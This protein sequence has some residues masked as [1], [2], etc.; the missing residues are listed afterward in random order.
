MK[1]SLTWLKEFV[2]F[3][4]PPQAL[5]DRLTA[6]GCEITAIEQAGSDWVIESEITP[7]RPDLLSHLGLAREI[8]AALGREFRPPRWLKRQTRPFVGHGNAVPVVIEEAE[9]CRRYIGITIDNV[10]VAPST[11]D[12]QKRLLALGI[13]PVNNVVDITNLCMLELGQPLHAFDLDLLEGQTVRVRRAKPKEKLVTIDGAARELSHEMLVIADAKKPV[14]LAGVMGGTETEITTSTKSVFLESA[15]FDPKRIRASSKSAKLS[16]DS[17]YRFERGVD[18]GM[19]QTAAVRAARMICL[20]GGG[21]ISRGLSEAGHLRLHKRRITLRPKHAQEV[22]G[23]RIYPAQQKKLLQRIGCT[24]SGSARNWKVEPPSW[25][26]DLRITED[27]NEELARLFGYERCPATL[28]P[29]FR[30]PVTPG[31]KPVEDPTIER[32][33]LVRRLL[34]E[35][36]MQEIMTYSLLH[37]DDEKKVKAATAPIRLDE[38]LSVD[39]AVVR[40]QLLAGALKTLA[41]NI[42]RKTSDTFRFF[43]IGRVFV[44]GTSPANPYRLGLLIAGT[45]APVWGVPSRP[46][47]IYELKGA[48]EFLFERLR[49]SPAGVPAL[50]DPEI[51][52]AFDIPANVAV[53]YA[54]LDLEK[55]L[56]AEPAPLKVRPVAKVPPVSRD[57]AVVVSDDAPYERLSSAIERAG[58]PL[59]QSVELFDLYKGK[60]VPSGKI[61]LAFRLAFAE[62]DRTLTDEEIAAAHEKIV[63]TLKKEF[64]ALLRA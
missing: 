61:S 54:E 15:W 20:Y 9:G 59:L 32:M 28:P 12:I 57:L 42:H 53:A 16:S 63:E 11:P 21:R 41:W 22:L 38:P 18:L 37:P 23:M 13:R 45:S 60:Q 2:E 31:W 24:V 1:Y 64:D 43:E 46:I 48:L 56:A 5:A 19:V 8:A 30:Q 49:V 14:A 34:A 6:A 58:R 27:L 47:G 35:A 33:N 17:S 55:L 39:Q 62:G 29:T 44:P 26:S 25:R 7:N 4:L 52:A 50:L 36:G 10:K 40:T 51:C 3:S